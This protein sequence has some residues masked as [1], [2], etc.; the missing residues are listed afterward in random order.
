MT[1]QMNKDYL[2]AVLLAFVAIFWGGSFLVVKYMASEITAVDLGFLRFLIATPLML[3]YCIFTKKLEVPSRRQ[4]PSLVVLGLTGV[5]FLYLFQFVGIRLTNAST[6][7]VLINTNVIFITVLSFVFLHERT[8]VRQV[9]GVALSFGGVVGV[10]FSNISIS[11]LNFSNS[12]FLGCLLMLL[13]ALCWAVYSVVGKQLLRSMNN[14][15]VTTYAFLLGTILYL[16]FVFRS[17]PGALSVLSFSG[18]L[19]VLY[20]GLFCSIFCYLGW[21]N[22]LSK[23]DAGRA[24][25]FLN[26]IPLSAIGL[27]VVV[28]E[29][30]TPLFLV[31]AVLIVYGVHLA[32][33]K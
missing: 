28:G 3:L 23:I 10:V 11:Q 6:A 20:L 19:A 17:I 18:W 2:L 8:T 9:V 15:T 26:V 21:Y 24:A 12:F 33:K 1:L 14:L 22:A 29:L 7:S 32:Y 30:I 31:G 5:T 13:S 25:V 16:P 4:I 27:S